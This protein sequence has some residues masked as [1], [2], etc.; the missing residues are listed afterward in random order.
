MSTASPEVRKHQRELTEEGSAV[1]SDLAHLTRD[2][3]PSSA[4]PQYVRIGIMFLLAAGFAFVSYRY[5][6]ALIR[7]G[8]LERQLA[9]APP[10]E[11]PRI[12]GELHHEV[13]T[14]GV[15]GLSTKGETGARGGTGATGATGTTGATGATGATGQKGDK[16]DK[17]DTVIVPSPFPVFVPGPMVTITPPSLKPS[18]TP[19][20]RRPTDT[21][22]FG[23]TP[24]PTPSPSPCLL[25]VSSTAVTIG[26]LVCPP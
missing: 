14:S 4:W 24:S 9:T 15:P 13:V 12:L 23:P 7:I 25:T 20:L 2:N 17:G 3:R 26:G 1:K 21:A 8:Q 19:R 16:G 10:S 5:S 6:A 18:P 22:T 11:R